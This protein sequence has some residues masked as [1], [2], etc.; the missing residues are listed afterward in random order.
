M[1]SN[2]CKTENHILS[3]DGKK[4]HNFITQKD[5]DSKA[6][7]AHQRSPTQKNSVKLRELWSL[8]KTVHLS[9]KANTTLLKSWEGDI[10]RI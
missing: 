3:S 10:E 4:D 6:T 5:G 7:E 8:F 2:T 1:N 9:T